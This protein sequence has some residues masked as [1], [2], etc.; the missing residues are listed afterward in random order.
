MSSFKLPTAPAVALGLPPRCLLRSCEPTCSCAV[1][2]A[3]GSAPWSRHPQW[4]RC[5]TVC[6]GKGAG[7]R[8]MW[9][10]Y[11]GC[12]Q[13]AGQLPK[14]MICVKDS[15]LHETTAGRFYWF[16][17]METDVFNG[18]KRQQPF[19]PF[20]FSI[21]IREWLSLQKLTSLWSSDCKCCSI[22]SLPS[23]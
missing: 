23:L 1:C 14:T 19:C 16:R 9:G 3:D 6:S 2:L 12:N 13:L 11:K 17:F 10:R 4:R 15:P 7:P 5:R 22:A 18:V 20:L 21:T 8:W